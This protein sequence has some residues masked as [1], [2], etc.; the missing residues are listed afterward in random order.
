MFMCILIIII[1][2]TYLIISYIIIS[3]K[4]RKVKDLKALLEDQLKKCYALVPQIVDEI[5]KNR[6]SDEIYYIITTSKAIY[7]KSN[8][9]KQLALAYNRFLH[10]LRLLQL[11]S[12]AS[13]VAKSSLELQKIFLEIDNIEQKI[14]FQSK[15]YNDAVNEYNNYVKRISGKIIAN[16]LNRKLASLFLYNKK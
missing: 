7:E 3:E 14:N 5:T 11:A 8:N 16:I 4:T 15:F 10:G 1:I 12:K 6:I 9:T 2:L 13:T